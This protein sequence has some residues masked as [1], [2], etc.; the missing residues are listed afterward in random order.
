[1]LQSKA[2]EFYQV[3]ETPLSIYMNQ[4]FKPNLLRS[5][6]IL[7]FFLQKYN[8]PLW[9]CLSVDIQTILSEIPADTP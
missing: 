8:K 7:F 5:P 1:M 4:T 3:Q 2:F 6:S 9:C